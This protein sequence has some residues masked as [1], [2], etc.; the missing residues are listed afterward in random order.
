M[1]ELYQLSPK[2]IFIQ[3]KFNLPAIIFENK[4][5]TQ[6]NISTSKSTAFKKGLY[7]RLAT[8]PDLSLITMHNMTKPGSDWAALLEY[9]FNNRLSIYS[10]IIRSMKY[11]DATPESYQ[12]PSDWKQPPALININ[13]SCKMLDI[14]LNIRY[15]IT[16]KNKSRLFVSTGIT[17]YVMLNE[18]YVYNYENPADPAIKWKSWEGKTG[19]YKLSTI[20]FSTGYEYQLFRKLSVQVG[21]SSILVKGRFLF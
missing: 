11:Y 8:S 2:G 1:K 12:W 19:M 16:Q 9:R 21:S 14:P 18:K 20:N 7:L 13:A 6:T 10:G 3:S 5:A 15:D 4:V 17:S